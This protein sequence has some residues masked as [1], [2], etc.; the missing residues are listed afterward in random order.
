MGAP[1]ISLLGD[2]LLTA[3]AARGNSG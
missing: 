2:E 3:L 1:P